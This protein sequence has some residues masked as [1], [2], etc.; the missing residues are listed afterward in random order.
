MKK[1]LLIFGAGEHGRSV[2]EAVAASY[3]QEPYQDRPQP[4]RIFSRD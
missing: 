3:L 4:L 1:R 2:A